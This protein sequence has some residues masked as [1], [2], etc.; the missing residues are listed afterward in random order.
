MARQIWQLDLPCIAETI[1]CDDITER[2]DGGEV[3]IDRRV[4][5][6]TAYTQ[7][8]GQKVKLVLVVPLGLLDNQMPEAWKKTACL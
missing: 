8:R 3:A 7:E 5:A 1:D 4:A 2:V 6:I